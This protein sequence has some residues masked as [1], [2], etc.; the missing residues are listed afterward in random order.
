MSTYRLDRLFA[1]RS[2]ALVGA[3]PRDKSLGR[4]VLKN[5]R[6]GGWSGPLDLVNPKHRAIDGLQAFRSLTELPSAPD[7]VVITAPP[8][9][10]PGLV[11][12][13]ADM[14]VAAAIII[15]AGL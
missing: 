9:T 11:A 1:P 10:V 14:G 8:D 4:A 13:A 15:T 2:V 6:D 3:S 12:Q 5:L 7:L